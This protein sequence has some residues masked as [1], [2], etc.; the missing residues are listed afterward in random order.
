MTSPYRPM[1]CQC[2]QGLHGGLCRM[3]P[4]PAV[5]SALYMEFL[6]KAKKGTSFLSYLESIG[7]VDP[8][9]TINGL[10]DRVLA[11]P[12][13]LG[14]LELIQI[15]GVAISG[16]LNV[17]V[18]LVD[19]E[20]R[21]GYMEP[22]HYH[23][24]LFTRK[25]HPTGSLA[26]FYT[27]VSNNN[28]EIVGSV[29]GWLR[30]PQTYEFY[31]GNESGTGDNYPRNCK[32]LAEDAAAVALKQGVAFAP[33]LDKLGRGFVTALFLVHAGRGAEYIQNPLAAKQEIWSHKW[34]V[35][36][37]VEV[38]PGGLSVTTYLTVPQDC[39]MGVCAH[40]LGHLA[41]QWQDF[42]DP[43]YNRD[44]KFWKGTG[45]WDLMASGAHNYGGTIPAHPAGLHKSQHQWVAID[46]IDK[47]T[48][49]VIL[50][51][52]GE[53]GSRILKVT[54]NAF[55]QGQYLI[56][57]NRQRRG[58]DRYIPGEGLLIWRVDESKE[59]YAPATPGMQ[60]VQADGFQ[61]LESPIGNNQGD[62]S[63]PFPGTKDVASVSD[64]GNAST[65]FPEGKNSGIRIT[66]IRMDEKGVISFSVHIDISTT[67]K[68][69]DA[70]LTLGAPKLGSTAQP[71]PPLK[72]KLSDAV[73]SNDSAASSAKKLPTKVKPARKKVKSAE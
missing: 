19:F 1:G 25:T 53:A 17:I 33:A 21:K 26:D 42:Y 9:T 70:F 13:P 49:N 20:D 58:F 59:M 2:R 38:G 37:P 23:D 52:W 41:F 15:P 18:L 55:A 39:V 11:Q 16:Q 4:S 48:E 45:N 69:A 36:H 28:V 72:G 56:L 3:P 63:D 57:E 46:I 22:E 31:V 60:L 68:S 40:E 27:E 29:H 62:D 64:T 44:G 7:F 54:S 30:M 61:Q 10:D 71:K 14:L 12:T 50:K 5:L 24:L 67:S 66:N 65:S 8:S 73:G 47:S 35:D 34:T 6:R 43:N 32:R 51:P